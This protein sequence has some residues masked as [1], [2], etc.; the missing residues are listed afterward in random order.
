[1]EIKIDIDYLR[2]RKLM[3]GTPM[4]GGQC[5][6]VYSKSVAELQGICTQY[7]I[8]LAN[9][10]LYNESLI[11]R[12]RAYVSDEFMRSDCTNL[13]FIDS[14]IG[15]N[16][17]DVLAMLSLQTDDSP[18]DILCAPYPKKNISWEKVKTAVDKGMGDENP[19]NLQNYMGDF[20]FNPVGGILNLTEPS[21]VLESGTGFMMIRRATFEKYEEAYPE[22]KYKPDH[23]RTEHFDGSREIMMY[24]DTPI[25]G[26]RNNIVEELGLFLADK[27]RATHDEI[28]AFVKDTKNGYK[29]Y[30]DRYLSE[31]Y[32][33][34]QR[35]RKA[36]MS[37]YLCPWINLVH[38]G[39]MA[40]GGSIAALASIEEHL[41]ADPNKVKKGG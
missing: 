10:N 11:T 40:F 38:F 30:T 29:K 20:V 1:M 2:S 19:N 4:Y 36:G 31:D 18:Y 41:T 14:D 13:L 22:L 37:V 12:A 8:P 5:F 35:S 9:Y 25:D 34:C 15:F 26:K 3:I 23:V 7:G 16:P 24:F 17:I 21:E 39:N 6:G 28:L 33:F 27:P 32:S